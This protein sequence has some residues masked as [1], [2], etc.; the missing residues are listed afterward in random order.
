VSALVP[1]LP[2]HAADT[3]GRF[4]RAHALTPPAAGVVI[5]LSGGIDSAL[6][7][8]LARDALGPEHV[9]GVLL[10]DA[11][12]PP[13]LRAETEAFA[14]AL[15][16]E[17]RTIAID[18]AEA[19]VRAIVPELSDRVD[20]GNV[21]ARLR[22]IALY[23]IARPRGRLV[24]GTG[25]KSE[26]LVGYFTKYGDGGADLLPLGDLYKTEVRALAAELGLPP[27]VLDR[28]PTAGLWAG[29]T[30]EGE[31]GLPYAELD[32][33]LVGLEQLL[34]EEAIADRTGIPLDRVH[35]VVGRVRASRHK[36]R[37]PPIPKLGLRTVG[38]DWR[39]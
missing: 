10:P 14:E 31:L 32:Q 36:R 12:F 16:I 28:P 30:D 5:G 15:G 37:L 6:T 8:R 20:V 22:M 25:N 3:I 19:G 13:A 17:H 29:Q 18:P 1:S 2:P 4:L 21:K 24:A 33:I 23:A 38:L 34:P 35:A 26:L 11:G 9:L 39:E 27:A 7:A